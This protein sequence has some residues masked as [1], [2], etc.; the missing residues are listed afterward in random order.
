MLTAFVPPLTVYIITS[1][2]M[3]TFRVTKSH[4]KT[5]DSIIEGAN[6]VM[7]AASPL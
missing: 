6:M 1:E 2:P 5:A 4:P 7:P 3:I